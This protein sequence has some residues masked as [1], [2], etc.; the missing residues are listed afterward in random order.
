MGAVKF[1][2]SCTGAS[3]VSEQNRTTITRLL[4]IYHCTELKRAGRSLTMAL[5]LANIYSDNATN[6][7][8]AQR[9][10]RDVFLADEFGN[11]VL[12]HLEEFNI[13]WHFIPA[14]SPHFGGLWEAGI[15]AVKGHIKRVIG[16]TSLTYEEMYTLLTGIET[17]L[18]S[19]PLCPL[20]EDPSDLNVLRLSIST[21][22]V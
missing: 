3:H 11:I 7:V 22:N 19:R 1:G 10:L 8:G 6:F 18:N 17:C 16:Q 2:K 5:I 12:R 9:E 20:T 15:K 14:R 21:E 13:N 4:A